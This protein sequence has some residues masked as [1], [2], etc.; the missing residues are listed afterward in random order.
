[1]DMS[2]TST[3]TSPAAHQVQRLAAVGGFAGDP[4]VDLVAEELAQAGAHHGVVV[5]DVGAP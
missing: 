5:D 1:M 4:Q 2:I 3:S